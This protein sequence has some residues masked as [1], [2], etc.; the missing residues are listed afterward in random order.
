MFKKCK[1]EDCKRAIQN[2]PNSKKVGSRKPR[3]GRREY[4]KKH[5]CFHKKKGLGNFILELERL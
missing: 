5:W 3:R 2:T 4:C 1:E